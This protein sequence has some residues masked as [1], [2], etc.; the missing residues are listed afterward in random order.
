MHALCE[1]FK[2]WSA[3]LLI[4]LLLTIG[5]GLVAFF[6][7]LPYPPI[8]TPRQVYL[9]RSQNNVPYF[10]ETVISWSLSLNR[11]VIGRPL[12]LTYSSIVLNSNSQLRRE[13]RRAKDKEELIHLPS[14]EHFSVRLD[15][16]A[17]Q[18]QRDMS[19][20]LPTSLLIL[21]PLITAQEVLKNSHSVNDSKTEVS[22]TPQS[23]K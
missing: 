14:R 3:L 1:L 13:F 20:L 12:S 5:I 4:S 22:S 15:R 11:I 2:R 18:Q 8:Q 6:F 16:E 21:L 19:N 10:L 7:L 9:R 23:S 17:L